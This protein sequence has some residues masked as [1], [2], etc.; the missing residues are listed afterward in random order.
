M[1]TEKVKLIKQLEE[2]GE[3]NF[4]KK[5]DNPKDAFAYYFSNF[6]IN[7]IDR[8]LSNEKWY[9]GASKEVYLDL[10][11]AEFNNFKKE[12]IFY[13]KPLPGICNGCKNGCS[14]FIFLD[15]ASG[16][17]VN[18]VI[19]V[20]DSEIVDLIECLNFTPDTPNDYL[21]EQ[22]VIKPFVKFDDIESDIPF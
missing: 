8:L 9:D 16:F 10:M 2:M 5:F 6:D 13:L 22:I 20:K 18:M 1:N 14:G 11:N 15:E 3:V 21:K 17:Y 7:S 19:E 4:V 12:N